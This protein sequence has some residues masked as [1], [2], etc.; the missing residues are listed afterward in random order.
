MKTFFLV[1]HAHRDIIHSSDDN[2]L[3][4]KGRRQSFAIVDFFET[5]LDGKKSVYLCSSPRVR[6][7]ETLGPLSDALKKELH[8]DP[9]LDESAHQKRPLEKSID[10]FL[11]WLRE[12]KI[13]TVIAC[14]HG[15]WIPV[16]FDKVTGHEESLKKSGLCEFEFHNNE[17][18]IKKIH[19]AF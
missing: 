13:E 19:G 8:I 14:S 7:Q 4:E 17:F 6:C 5:T 1:R 16:F 15:D 9:L 11:Q 2:G 3:S 10:L 18:K 12:Q